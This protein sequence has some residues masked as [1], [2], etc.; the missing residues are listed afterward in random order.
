[1]TS[2]VR[3]D[4]RTLMPLEVFFVVDRRGVYGRPYEFRQDAEAEQSELCRVHPDGLFR[5]VHYELRD[6]GPRRGG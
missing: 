6:A 1:M 5:V 4:L 2:E 3:R